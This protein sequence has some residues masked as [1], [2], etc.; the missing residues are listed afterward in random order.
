[1]KKFKI[2]ILA[3]KH[4][5]NEIISNILKNIKFK[6]QNIKIVYINNNY[7]NKNLIFNF[8]INF[9][10]YIEKKFIGKKKNYSFL[11]IK[12]NSLPRI[13]NKKYFVDLLINLSSQTL[14][15]KIIKSS[16][17]GV[18]HINYGIKNN[19]FAG[20]WECLL[21]FEIVTAQL[22]SS[23]FI[24]K[25]FSSYCIDQTFLNNKNNFWI[26]NKE[27]VTIKASNLIFKNINKIFFNIKITKITNVK[28]K[29]FPA[30][31]IFYLL[32]YILKK[33][34]LNFLRKYFI[35]IFFKKKP[36]WKIFIKDQ[37]NI[38]SFYLENI[39]FNAKKITPH[40][41]YEWADPF[42]FEH[43]NKNYIFFENNDLKLNKGKISCGLIEGNKLINIKDIL[44]FN[45]HLSYPFI[46]KHK[47]NIY[48]IPESSSN[49]SIQI[50][51]A[52]IFPYKWNLFKTFLKNEYCCDTTIINFNKNNWLLTNKSND[53]T[54]DPNNELY[55]YKIIGNLKKI[56]PHKLNPVLTDCR[57][58]R[59]AGYLNYQKETIRPSQINNSSGYGIGIN[60]NK[61]LKLNM[62]NYKEKIVRKIYPP[63]N[64]K[65][66]GL[67]HISNSK[68]KIV[69]DVRE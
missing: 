20:F 65:M 61:I 40:K 50:W 54:D 16:K 12:N 56:I 37:K 52:R 32:K 51:K 21:N 19:F 15:K 13:K 69:F 3:K 18:W 47:N 7:K 39:F 4:I 53:R 48:L 43:N 17:F 6:Q 9:I 67:H 42:I 44:N 60:I 1:M 10:I 55:V 63:K 59:N 45:Y 22:I 26:R 64:T 30:V 36:L 46:W 29:K 35:N 31:D 62:T 57:I 38:E 5:H 27:F 28:Y 14:S 49:K 24:G 58:A 33:Y 68:S 23:K 25:K 11:N 2:I 34:F 41:T 8:L 66:N